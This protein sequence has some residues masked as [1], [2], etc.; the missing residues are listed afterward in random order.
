MGQS[1]YFRCVRR[2]ADIISD[3]ILWTVDRNIVK[4]CLTD[5]TESVNTYPATLKSQG[6]IPAGKCF[7]DKDR[8]CLCRG[9]ST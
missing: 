8:T 7:A 1:H 4:N 2:T 6:A 9:T 5:V 3:S